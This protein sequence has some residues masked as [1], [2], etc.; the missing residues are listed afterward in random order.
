MDYPLDQLSLLD[1]R[2]RLVTPLKLCTG[3]PI[4]T[5]QRRRRAFRSFETVLGG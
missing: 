3:E 5:F 2:P 1:V 4:V